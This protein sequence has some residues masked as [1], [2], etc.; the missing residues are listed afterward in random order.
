MYSV[1]L[2]RIPVECNLLLLGNLVLI[3]FGNGLHIVQALSS[4]IFLISSIHL[5]RFCNIKTI[6]Y[7]AMIDSGAESNFIQ[8]KIVKQLN[9]KLQ[10]CDIVEIITTGDNTCNVNYKVSVTAH[11]AKH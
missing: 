10:K 5:F 2:P 7:L 4:R 3:Y 8:T 11:L 6:Y 9:S 1:L